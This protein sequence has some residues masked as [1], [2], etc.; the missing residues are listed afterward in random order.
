MGGCGTL[1]DRVDLAEFASAKSEIGQV[2][3]AEM[4]GNDDDDDDDDDDDEDD[5]DWDDDEPA[6]SISARL[7]SAE[8]ASANGEFG[9]VD[10]AAKSDPGRVDLAM[11]SNV[12]FTQEEWDREV[13]GAP[14]CDPV[15]ERPLANPSTPDKC[16]EGWYRDIT[17]LM[18][19]KECP[20]GT[21]DV[22]GICWN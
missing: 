17:Q 14:Q 5:D 11:E 3:L 7:I 18:C 13:K 9:Q 10:T 16:P 19:Y 21:T 15:K 6:V 20:P 12:F 1:P 22:A 8:I 2:D 4:D